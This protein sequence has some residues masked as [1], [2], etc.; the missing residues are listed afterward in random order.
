MRR[1]SIPA[2]NSLR[3]VALLQTAFIGDVALLAY[4]AEALRDLAPSLRISLITQPRAASL[5]QCFNAV[6]AVRIYDKRAAHKGLAGMRVFADELRLEQI[7]CILTPHP[8]LRSALLTRLLRPAIGI[9]YDRSAGAWL[10]SRRVPYA[11]HLHEA[12]RL[13]RLLS[14]FP[15]YTKIPADASQIRPH[16]E[17]GA[18]QARADAR[19]A[20]LGLH[21]DRAMVVCAPGSEWATKRW[22]EDR[23][24]AC[25]S[26][27]N[28]L[29]YQTL[30]IGAAGDSALAKRI[31]EVSRTPSLAGQTSLAEVLG[32][33][34]RARV[35]ISNDSAPAHLAGLVDCP[36]VALFGPTAPIFG[37]RPLHRPSI[38]LENTSLTCRPCSIHGGATCPLGTHECLRSIEP[39]RVLAAVQSLLGEE[40]QS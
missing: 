34:N 23:V 18:A 4:L 5:A 16:I 33:L 37:F 40:E 8:S 6:D 32:I 19:L 38:V 35:L 15:E 2:L 21:T 31:A 11:R 10:F 39:D 27:L 7:D 9:G 36:V 17:V 26:A 22:P 1:A 24:A 3:H 13:L 14:V 29:G 28:R 20:A 12:D 25:L 30:L